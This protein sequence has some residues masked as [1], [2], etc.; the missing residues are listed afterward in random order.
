[1]SDDELKKARIS[2]MPPPR[3]MPIRHSSSSFARSNAPPPGGRPTPKAPIPRVTVRLSAV[4]FDVV[5][6]GRRILEGGLGV[7]PGD[8]VV[9]LLDRARADLASVLVEVAQSLG[10]AALVFVMEEFGD[11]PLRQLPEA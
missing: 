9:V 5:N 10:A 11:R 1:M 6:A 8:R 2:S 7:V 3:P 4:D